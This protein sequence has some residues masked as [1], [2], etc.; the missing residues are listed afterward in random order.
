M[1]T[2]FQALKPGDHIVSSDDM[3]FGIRV[4]LNEFFAPWGLETTTYVDMSDLDGRTRGV[5]ARRPDWS[6]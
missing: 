1:L 4:Q 3:Y 5:A 2:I 6:S